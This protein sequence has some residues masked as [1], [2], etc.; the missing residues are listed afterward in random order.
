MSLSS[1]SRAFTLF[2]ALATACMLFAVVFAGQARAGAPPPPETL[3]VSDGTGTHTDPDVDCTMPDQATIQAAVTE[4]NPGDTIAVCSGTYEENV[5]INKND[6]TFEGAQAGNDAREGRTD[7]SMESVVT[8]PSGVAFNAN[9]TSGTTIDGFQFT[10][11]G[12]TPVSL[13]GGSGHTAINNVIEDNTGEHGIVYSSDGTDSS[14][15]AQNR[16]VDNNLHGIFATGPAKNVTIEDNFFSEHDRSA[17]HFTGEADGTTVA[18]NASDA[19]SSFLAGTDATGLTITENTVTNGTGSGMALLGGFDNIEI[20]DNT[21]TGSASNG[22]SLVD[23]GNFGP[24]T[25]VTI[26]GNT[27]TGNVRGVNI[28]DGGSDDTLEVRQNRIFNNDTGILNED[29][30]TTVDAENNWWGCNE[31]PNED[32]CDTTDGDVDSDPHIVMDIR[33]KPMRVAT[34]GSSEIIVRFL[35]NKGQGQ[36]AVAREFPDGTPIDFDAMRGQVNPN[37]QETT[38]GS[39]T[40]TLTTNSKKKAAIVTAGLDAE[41]VRVRIKIRR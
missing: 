27:L 26:L 9:N 15:F 7:T 31:G 14:R 22:I 28:G 23:I 40:T 33:A 1:K 3:V 29:T 10:G 36:P 13:I 41:S 24:N 19:D 32:G 18:N 17:V 12:T 11:G 37:Q 30:E 2:A 16:I 25:N 21:V 34:G 38:N 5:T 8:A 4:A 35:L 20:T 39:A 6:L